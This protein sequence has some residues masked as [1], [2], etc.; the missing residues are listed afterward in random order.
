MDPELPDEAAG[1]A[2]GR[3]RLDGRRVLVIGAGTRHTDDPDAPIGNGRAI[4]ALAAREGAMVA[5]ADRD[6]AAALA[7]AELIVGNG[8]SAEVLVADVSRAED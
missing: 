6:E 3:G 1:K 8:G 2:P 7:T 5:C 4:A